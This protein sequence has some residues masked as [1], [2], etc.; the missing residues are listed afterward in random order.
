MP[1]N[2][3]QTNTHTDERYAPSQWGSTGGLEDLEMPSGQM[4]QVRRPGPQGLIEAGVIHS[5]DALTG[6]VQNELIPQA[7]GTPKIDVKKLM[8]NESALTSIIHTADRVV[9]HC[10]VQ[11]KVEM[12]PNDV[13]SRKPGVIYADMI[14][15]EDKMFIMQF[16][17]GGTRDVATFREESKKAVGGVDT[18]EES[19]STTKRAPRNK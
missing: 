19:A 17:M 7:E 4:A 9:V 3:E 5:L 10:V 18:L 12:T 8:K 1:V 11:P 14:D 6:I 15:L 16:A 13:T 2:K